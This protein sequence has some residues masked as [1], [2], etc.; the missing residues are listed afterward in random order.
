VSVRTRIPIS[1]LSFRPRY[2]PNRRRPGFRLLPTFFTAFLTAAFECGICSPRTDPG[3]VAAGHASPVLLGPRRAL[4]AVLIC[5]LS[6]DR[7]PGPDTGSG[8]YLSAYE[9]IS[10][11]L[12][13]ADFVVRHR[14]HHGNLYPRFQKSR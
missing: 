10:T 5:L 2:R 7:T 12:R 11:P 14:P 3:T 13:L 9:L 4:P 1:A 8:V 6:Y